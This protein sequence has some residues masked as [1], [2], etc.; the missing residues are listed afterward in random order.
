MLDERRRMAPV[1]RIL[2]FSVVDGPGNRTAVFL[3][4]C[5]LHCAYCHNPETQHMCAHCGDCVSVCPVGA[6]WMED[7]KVRWS[8]EKCVGCDA[9]IRRCERHA[10]PK[11]TFM[12][13]EAVMERVAR[14][15][16]FIRGL[17]TSGGECGL[18]PE[19]LEELYRL[20]HRRGLTCLMD[21]NGAVDLARYPSLM[22]VCDGVML[23]VKAWD[24]AVFAALTGGDQLIVRRNLRW[25]A[26]AGKL[27]EVRVVTLD[28]HVDAEACVLGTAAV[29]GGSATAKT[30]L[31]LIRFRPNGVRGALA[32]HPQP[33]MERMRKLEALARSVG[34]RDVRI[35]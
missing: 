22:E 9:C 30:P 14:N 11:V 10:S 32:G 1:N 2:S 7:G 27:E 23:D 13:P 19:F 17:T 16:P 28:G 8:A 5:N 31:K 18:Y 24:P 6:L 4:A 29:L 20:A 33:T 35:L 21:S 26:D 34:F 3:Q 15:I 12:T 25:L